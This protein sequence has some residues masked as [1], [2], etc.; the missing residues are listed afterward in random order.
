MLQ[1]QAKLARELK[2]R[3]R[4]RRRAAALWRAGSSV[5][6]AQRLPP[7]CLHERFVQRLRRW[8]SRLG[9]RQREGAGRDRIEFRDHLLLPSA[10]LHCQWARQ[11]LGNNA[12]YDGAYHWAEHSCNVRQFYY[13][14]PKRGGD[15]GDD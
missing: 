13:R 10:R 6:G 14:Q 8:L 2:L 5:I 11:L 12:G 7:G 1:T 4:R 15:R 9:R 3:H